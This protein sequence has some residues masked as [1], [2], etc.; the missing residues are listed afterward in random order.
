MDFHP[1]SAYGAMRDKPGR[2]AAVFSLGEHLF[3]ETLIGVKPVVT[4][5]RALKVGIVALDSEDTLPVKPRFFK[6]GID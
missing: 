2:Y 4:S 3:Y 6:L 5:F 1:A